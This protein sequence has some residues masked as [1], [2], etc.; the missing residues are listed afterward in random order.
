MLLVDFNRNTLD[1]E[2]TKTKKS[3]KIFILFLNIFF[4]STTARKKPEYG[5]V[6][7]RVG[8]DYFHI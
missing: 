3:K 2:E 8:T 7:Y 6:F 5:P 1:L 4:P